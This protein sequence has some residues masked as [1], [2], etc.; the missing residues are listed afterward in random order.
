MRSLTVLIGLL[1]LGTFL[2]ASTPTASAAAYCVRDVKETVPTDRCDGL[3]CYGYNS[4]TG[5]QTCVP[6]WCAYMSDCCQD[7]PTGSGFY[8]P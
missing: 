1:A 7:T 2:V 8:C 4:Q 5:W 6:D 3:V